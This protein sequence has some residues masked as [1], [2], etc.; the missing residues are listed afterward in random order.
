MNKDS[1]EKSVCDF[2]AVFLLDE[3]LPEQKAN[4]RKIRL[5]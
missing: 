4:K 5:Q 3:G 1:S 2:V